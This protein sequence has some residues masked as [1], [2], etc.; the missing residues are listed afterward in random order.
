MAT[1]DT[2]HGRLVFENE[3]PAEFRELIPEFNWRSMQFFM[4]RMFRGK[5]YFN[6][7]ELAGF[8][9]EMKYATNAFDC[10][11]LGASMSTHKYCVHLNYYCDPPIQFL[12]DPEDPE[13]HGEVCTL[14]QASLCLDDGDGRNDG[15]LYIVTGG[16]DGEYYV[17]L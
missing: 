14:F 17:C 4:D 9:V 12:Y 10:D 8:Q 16:G 2:E 15:D 6:S 5:M 3:F 13:S 1:A 11:C 7:S